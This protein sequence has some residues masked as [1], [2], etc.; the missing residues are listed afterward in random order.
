MIPMASPGVSPYFTIIALL[1]PAAD[2]ASP[3]GLVCPCLSA[4]IVKFAARD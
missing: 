1:F 3:E 4:A 2:T